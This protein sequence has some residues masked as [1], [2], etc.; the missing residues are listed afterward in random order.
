MSGIALGILA[1]KPSLCNPEGSRAR[2][3]ADVLD[4]SSAGRFH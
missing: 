1:L 4:V 2:N 3:T